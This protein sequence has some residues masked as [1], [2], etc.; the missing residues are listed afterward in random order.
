MSA[1]SQPT[2]NVGSLGIYKEEDT[3]DV[4]GAPH[5]LLKSWRDLTTSRRSS[6]AFLAGK[7]KFDQENSYKTFCRENV[8]E[9]P[10]QTHRDKTSSI[11]SALS[12]I[13]MGIFP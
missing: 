9:K 1:G 11:I 4:N 13:T 3:V 6:G 7:K 12:V 8:P 5:F 10:L 2:N